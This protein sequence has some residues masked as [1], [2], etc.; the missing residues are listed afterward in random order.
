MLCIGDGA[1]RA[2]GTTGG[3]NSTTGVR[4]LRGQHVRTRPVTVGKRAE[5]SERCV[6]ARGG[7]ATASTLIAGNLFAAAVEPGTWWD[8]AHGCLIT[9]ASSLEFQVFPKATVVSVNLGHGRI[10]GQRQA[11]AG[12]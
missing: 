11:L 9:W 5:G 1:S 7:P 8:G 10:T 6:G 3:I 4:L 12:S 2:R